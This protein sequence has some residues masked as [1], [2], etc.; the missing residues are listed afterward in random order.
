MLSIS[1]PAQRLDP[2]REKLGR[3]TLIEER[4]VI[5]HLPE[6]EMTDKLLLNLREA[7][8][9]LGISRNTFYRLLDTGELPGSVSV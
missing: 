2:A 9:L 4:P 5:N 1:M 3:D 6:I 8:E 7:S